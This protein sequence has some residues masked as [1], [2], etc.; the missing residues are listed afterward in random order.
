MV[1]LTDTVRITNHQVIESVQRMPGNRLTLD[2]DA[3]QGP[4]E[5]ALVLSALYP[6]LISQSLISNQ[7]R[8]RCV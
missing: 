1:V 3:R 2:P 4:L 7:A 6:Q 8:S 5:G